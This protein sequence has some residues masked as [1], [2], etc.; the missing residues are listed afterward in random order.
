LCGRW[1]SDLACHEVMFGWQWLL[2]HPDGLANI[3]RASPNGNSL[4]SADHRSGRV[5]P[6]TTHTDCRQR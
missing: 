6:P 1:H 2:H 5:L 4:P 3:R